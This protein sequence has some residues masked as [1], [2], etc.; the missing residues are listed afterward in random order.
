MSLKTNLGADV[1]VKKR[2]EVNSFI[3]RGQIFIGAVLG[4]VQPP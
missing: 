2:T 1:S 3:V 4:P